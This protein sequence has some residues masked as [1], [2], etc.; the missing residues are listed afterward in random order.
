M[1]E[2]PLERFSRLFGHGDY[3]PQTLPRRRRSGD[4]RGGAAM[5]EFTMTARRISEL[6]RDVCFG[7]ASLVPIIKQAAEPLLEISD[8]YR[9]AREVGIIGYPI[10]PVPPTA[11]GSV[12]PLSAE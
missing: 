5:N 11:T 1:D 9:R 10:K 2:T 6:Q 4:R 3:T 8:A 12:S 7:F